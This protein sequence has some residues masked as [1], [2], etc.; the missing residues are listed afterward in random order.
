MKQFSDTVTHESTKRK[1][2]KKNRIPS[3]NN[4]KQYKIEIELLFNC[5]L[6]PNRDER[7]RIEEYKKQKRNLTLM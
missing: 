1:E 2:Q 6:T 3:R 4:R 7:K 5:L